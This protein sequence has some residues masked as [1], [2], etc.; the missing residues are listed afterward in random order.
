MTSQLI[1]ISHDRL[2]QYWETFGHVSFY[3]RVNLDELTT[4]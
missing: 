3:Q 1:M 2:A 4:V